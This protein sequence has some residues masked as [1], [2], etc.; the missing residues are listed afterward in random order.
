[1]IQAIRELNIEQGY[2]LHFLLQFRMSDVWD[3]SLFIVSETP[4][5]YNYPDQD[6]TAQREK[7]DPH[8]QCQ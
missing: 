7:G 6:N 2:D 1:M 5:E 4:I 8:E 3:D